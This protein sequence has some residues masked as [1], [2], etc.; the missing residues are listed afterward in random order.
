MF[1]NIHNTEVHNLYK[2]THTHTHTHIYK[3]KLVVQFSL[4]VTV[5]IRRTL[6]QSIHSSTIVAQI[7]F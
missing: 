5:N 3:M 7:P 2:Y 4:L 1:Y 6:I